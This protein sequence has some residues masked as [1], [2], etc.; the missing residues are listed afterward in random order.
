MNNTS[1]SG[2]ESPSA[3]KTP[4]RHSPETNQTQTTPRDVQ[5]EN[6]PPTVNVQRLD[7]LKALLMLKVLKNE[8]QFLKLFP[9]REIG[10]NKAVHQLNDW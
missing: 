7:L 3:G 8:E 6:N 4:N 10:E 2:N 9:E 1:D 5:D